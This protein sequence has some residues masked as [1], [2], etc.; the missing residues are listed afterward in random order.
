MQIF[1]YE[2]EG[3]YG[4]FILYEDTVAKLRLFSDSQW[5]VE[6]SNPDNIFA[7]FGIIPGENVK[8]TVNTGVTHKFSP[9]SDKVAE[10]EFYNYDKENKS[11]DMVYVTY[12][13][14]YF[15]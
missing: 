9:V 15:D 2:F 1:T 11:F 5:Q 7:M 13:L 10:V 14:N 8:Q 6:G 3:F 4:E 12:N